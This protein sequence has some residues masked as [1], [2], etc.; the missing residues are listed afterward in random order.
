LLSGQYRMIGDF[1]KRSVVL[2]PSS[3]AYGIALLT[4]DNGQL[5]TD[6][7]QR[8]SIDNRQSAIGNSCERDRK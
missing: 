3:L 7:G 5:T 1:S 2:G 6:D 4:T 8:S